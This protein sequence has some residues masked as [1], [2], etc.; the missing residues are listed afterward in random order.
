M[1]LPKNQKEVN[2]GYHSGENVPV[3][4]ICK[5][6]TPLRSGDVKV[7]NKTLQEFSLPEVQFPHAPVGFEHQQVQIPEYH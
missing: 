3:G 2:S 4:I 5:K 1:T 6:F 7:W